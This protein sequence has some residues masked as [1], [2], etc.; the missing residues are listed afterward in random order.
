MK[1]W[2]VATVSGNARTTIVDVVSEWRA[3]AT[4]IN[5]PSVRRRCGDARRMVGMT[6]VEAFRNSIS[7]CCGLRQSTLVIVAF[8]RQSTNAATP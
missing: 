5:P 4:W 3:A 8:R 7:E 6:V 1:M 2:A